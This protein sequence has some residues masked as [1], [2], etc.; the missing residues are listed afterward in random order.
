MT[1][2]KID[3]MLSSYLDGELRPEER[4]LV[5]A[6]L[7]ACPHCAAEL[8]ALER[9]AAGTRLFP[10]P[11]LSPDF[12]ERVL[13]QI[14]SRRPGVVLLPILAWSLA[15]LALA[16]GLTLAV[17]ALSSA[18]SALFSALA[19]TA[20]IGFR[21]SSALVASLRGTPEIMGA[22]SLAALL[23]GLAWAFRRIMVAL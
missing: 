16:S 13:D 22:V 14:Q 4:R 2:T 20:G 7:K 5:E 6:H 19:L 15:G 12:T 1:C 17:L 23:T 9:T 10:F 18:G 3:S 21:I 11:G 8:A